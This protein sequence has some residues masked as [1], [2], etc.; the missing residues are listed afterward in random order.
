M[1]KAILNVMLTSCLAGIRRALESRLTGRVVAALSC[2]TVGY[3]L[4]DATSTYREV[5]RCGQ[6]IRRATQMMTQIHEE[7]AALP[8][9]ESVQ[10][11]PV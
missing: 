10:H 1:K 9:R 5:S 11:R 4:I 3:T 7:R 2:G 8:S 6:I